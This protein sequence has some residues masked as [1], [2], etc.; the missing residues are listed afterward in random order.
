MSRR[1]GSGPQ[2]GEIF[3]PRAP[4]SDHPLKVK[5]FSNQKA[6][7]GGLPAQGLGWRNLIPYLGGSLSEAAAVE[8]PPLLPGAL[9]HRP[10]L[11]VSLPT[12]L[13]ASVQEPIRGLG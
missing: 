13:P 10:G 6:V 12:L 9:Q 8:G 1:S 4:G 11:P 7:R 5:G 3:F 2:R